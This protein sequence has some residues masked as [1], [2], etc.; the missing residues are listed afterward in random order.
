MTLAPRGA[1][2]GLKSHRRHSNGRGGAKVE[3]LAYGIGARIVERDYVFRIDAQV[4][5][6]LR[7]ERQ[8]WAVHEQAPVIR[9]VERDTGEKIQHP[10]GIVGTTSEEEIFECRELHRRF[11]QGLDAGS[12][13]DKIGRQ[14]QRRRLNEGI[15]IG[16]AV[17]DN[18]RQIVRRRCLVPEAR[19]KRIGSQAHEKL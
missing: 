9:P 18:A 3:K 14:R 13:P 10:M 12:S 11:T 8:K 5:Q 1:K 7:L 17:R 19:A 2:R 15:A 4:G 6:C 16:V